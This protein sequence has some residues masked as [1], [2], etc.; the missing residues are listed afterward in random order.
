MVFWWKGGGGLAKIGVDSRI[1]QN[2][3]SRPYFKPILYTFGQHRF[4]SLDARDGY[5]DIQYI[6]TFSKT[7]IQGTPKRIFPRKTKKS[8]LCNH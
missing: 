7:T 1:V 2:H 6:Q 4:S 3:F 8:L 5:G